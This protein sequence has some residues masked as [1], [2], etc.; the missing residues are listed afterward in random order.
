MTRRLQQALTKVDEQPR[1]GERE[2]GLPNRKEMEVSPLAREL[3]ANKVRLA[4]LKALNGVGFTAQELDAAV[5]LKCALE[6]M[7]SRL[8]TGA[9]SLLVPSGESEG[10]RIALATLR[11]SSDVPMNIDRNSLGNLIALLN[12]MINGALN[13]AQAQELLAQLPRAMGETSGAPGKRILPLP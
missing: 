6:H 11:Y 7:A 13:R 8:D 12:V 9:E 10:D 2:M 3:A 5:L 4:A 1:R